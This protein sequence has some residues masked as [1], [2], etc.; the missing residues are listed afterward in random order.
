MGC[1]QSSSQNNVQLY[2]RRHE[3]SLE[4]TWKNKKAI[5][6]RGCL[7]PMHALVPNNDTHVTSRFS[8]NQTISGGVFFILAKTGYIFPSFNIRNTGSS[9]ILNPIVSPLRLVLSIKLGRQQPLQGLIR[10]RPLTSASIR[11]TG[12]TRGW[13]WD[14]SHARP[15][16]SPS[17]TA[18][19]PTL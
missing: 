17:V 1:A 13:T 5:Q 7:D 14:I 10:L 15:R 11:L 8:A 3:R 6:L 4:P 18:L 2:Q 12:D 19:D 16:L 9:F